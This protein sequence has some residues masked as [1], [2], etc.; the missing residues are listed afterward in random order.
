MRIYFPGSGSQEDCGSN[1]IA[2][3]PVIDT[4]GF[5]LI[6]MW[7]QRALDYTQDGVIENAV[8]RAEM[9]QAWEFSKGVREKQ[10]SGYVLRT[11]KLVVLL[12]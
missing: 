8:D 1:K 4:G 3:Y 7:N 9:E 10:V 12:S 5:D 6:L 2:T 11:T